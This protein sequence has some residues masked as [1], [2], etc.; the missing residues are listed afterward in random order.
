VKP[1]APAPPTAIVAAGPS[2]AAAGRER[3]GPAIRDG[4][5]RTGAAK[6]E[7]RTANNQRQLLNLDAV[8]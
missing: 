6:K 2:A 4:G 7:A 8:G 3:D 5:L 1:A